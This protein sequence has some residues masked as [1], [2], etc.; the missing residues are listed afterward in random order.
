MG[1]RTF[2]GEIG[3]AKEDVQIDLRDAIALCQATEQ[4]LRKVNGLRASDMDGRTGSSQNAQISKELLVLAH[5]ADKVRG[6]I[7]DEYHVFKGENRHMDY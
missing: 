2:R 5:M 6:M 7:L 4:A 1:L 3:V